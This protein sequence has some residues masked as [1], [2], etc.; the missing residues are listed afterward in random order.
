LTIDA[1]GCAEVGHTREDLDDFIVALAEGGDFFTHLNVANERAIAGVPA[2]YNVE[3]PVT[4]K[5]GKMTRTPVRFNE[6]I[7]AE[8]AR[9]GREQHLI[10]Q[11]CRDY[12]EEL[13]IEAL[14]LDA[15]IASRGQAA[16]LVR[17]MVAFQREYISGA[18]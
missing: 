15:L 18:A 2:A 12:D 13:L 10:A 4:F 17:E 7:T 16:R 8:I 9:V 14:S 5:Q 1:E 6:T 3:L 11:A